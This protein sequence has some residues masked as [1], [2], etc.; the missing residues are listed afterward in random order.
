MP[1]R[2]RRARQVLKGPSPSCPTR[3]ATAGSFLAAQLAQEH[4]P[5]LAGAMLL[6]LRHH[7]RLAT[8]PE[9]S[10]GHVQSADKVEVAGPRW[11][12][13]ASGTAA[14]RRARAVII[15]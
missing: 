10:S 11:V 8:A 5:E 3:S 2:L 14:P 12:R 15:G 4:V 13:T 7:P 1:T 9:L 6:T